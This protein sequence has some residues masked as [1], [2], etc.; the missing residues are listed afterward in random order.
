MALSVPERMAQTAEHFAAHDQH[1]YSQVHR[2]DGGQ[3]AI[4]LSDGSEAIIS[5]SDVDCSEMVRQCV[6]VGLGGEVISYMWTG[7]QDSI[8]RGIGFERHGYSAGAVQRGDI[9]LR[10]GHT[11]IALGGGLQAEAYID[12]VGGITGPT[13]GDQTGGEVRVAALSS[14]TWIYRYPISVEPEPVPQQVPGDP[15]NDAGLWYRVHVADVGW[16]DA[17]RDGQAAGTTGAGRAVEAIR[18]QPPDGVV[19]AVEVHVAGV[20]WVHYEGVQAGPRDSACD[21]VMGTTGEG[22]AV[23]AIRIESRTGQ[24]LRYRVHVAEYGW[25]TWVRDGEATGSVGEGRRIEA[26]QIVLEA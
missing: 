15:V 7:N 13:R 1:G 3:E 9:L 21:P 5:A 26:I 6:N 11:G 12:E 25:T 22:R 24:R 19:L 20:G 17:V 16:L 4:T 18:I 14:W 23:E 10:Q 8:L 2:G